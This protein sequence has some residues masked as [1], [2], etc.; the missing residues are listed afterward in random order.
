MQVRV[1]STDE[2]ALRC[3]WCSEPLGDGVERACPECRAR[4]HEACA[5]ELGPACP[6]LGCSLSSARATPPK[7][8]APPLR[9]WRLAWRR[10]RAPIIGLVLGLGLVRGLERARLA[11]LTPAERAERAHDHCERAGELSREAVA[12]LGL[13]GPIYLPP[14]VMQEMID[15]YS[16]ALELDPTHVEALHS[17][18]YWHLYKHEGS[19]ALADYD[20]LLELD[21]GNSEAWYQRGGI[22][23]GRGDHA[24]AIADYT[25]S[26]ELAPN[27]Y[28]A[29]RGARARCHEHLGDFSAALADLQAE[30]GGDHYRIARCLAAL[31]R[32]AE[33]VKHYDVVLAR[34][35]GAAETTYERG[36]SRFA[37][38]DRAGALEDFQRAFR[39]GTSIASDRAREHMA[40]QPGDSLSAALLEALGPESGR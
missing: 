12:R 19:A 39:S 23:C 2:G 27:P 22:H 6:T 10:L 25:R 7:D 30:G 35:A 38:G 15:E 17:R 29:M 14:D 4:T 26:I 11:S 40:A 3:G 18:A 24:R 33:A 5:N 28:L 13:A 21:P 16:R 32:H 31:G 34:S 37:A 9:G 1:T 8:A 20:Q 36:L